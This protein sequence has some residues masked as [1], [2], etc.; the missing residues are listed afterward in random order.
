[1]TETH[2]LQHQLKILVTTV[3]W[4][5]PLS[6]KKLHRRNDVQGLQC[7]VGTAE[8][9]GI[10]ADKRAVQRDQCAIWHVHK[11]HASN[12]ILANRFIERHLHISRSTGE[13]AEELPGHSLNSKVATRMHAHNTTPSTH[14]SRNV[15]EM[16]QRHTTG[17]SQAAKPKYVWI[18]PTL[19]YKIIQHHSLSKM[20]QN[21]A[22][23][24]PLCRAR[25]P[26]LRTVHQEL[27]CLAPLKPRDSPEPLTGRHP[28][29][30]EIPCRALRRE[31]RHNWTKQRF[32]DIRRDQS[33]FLTCFHMLWQFDCSYFAVLDWKLLKQTTKR[34]PLNIAQQPYRCWDEPWLRAC[35]N[36]NRQRPWLGSWKTGINWLGQVVKTWGNVG[37]SWNVNKCLCKNRSN[38]NQ[39]S[40][41]FLFSGQSQHVSTA[42]CESARSVASIGRKRE[43]EEKF[44]VCK[45]ACYTLDHPIGITLAP[46]ARRNKSEVALIFAKSHSRVQDCLQIPRLLQQS[47]GWLLSGIPSPW[48]TLADRGPRTPRS[49]H[50]KEAAACCVWQ[51]DIALLLIP[52]GVSSMEYSENGWHMATQCYT[53]NKA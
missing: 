21:D 5:I 41:H 30:T 45:T 38:Q 9:C 28:R 32:D 2:N 25:G 40:M 4:G 18:D 47:V 24:G 15:E 33:I 13:K 31:P 6:V 44:V 50:L 49:P 22:K 26:V 42:C 34:I 12:Q 52:V 19:E 14:C 48:S 17:E 23:C 43:L 27:W 46:K 7:N 39:L 36:P 35:Q 1:M 53:S 10:H 11:W 16:T 51:S 37:T 20:M 8:G 3:S 29:N